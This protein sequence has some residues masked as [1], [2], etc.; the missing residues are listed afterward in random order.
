M[1]DRI[2]KTKDERP[3]VIAADRLGSNES[4]IMGNL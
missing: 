3:N 4:G 2:R 1:N